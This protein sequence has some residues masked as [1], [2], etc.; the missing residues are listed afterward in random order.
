MSKE[1]S[2][3]AVKPP[4]QPQKGILMSKHNDEPKHNFVS[5]LFGMTSK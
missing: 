4:I 2:R 1:L 3:D 5:G